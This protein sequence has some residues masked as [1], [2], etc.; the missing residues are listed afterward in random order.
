MRQQH[1]TK[2]TLTPLSDIHHAAYRCLD[3]EQTRWFYED[4]MGLKMGIALIED[5]DFGEDK[6]RKF[7]HIF[8]E[9]TNG[10]SVAFFD[11]P[12]SATPDDFKRKD[13]FN[14]HLAFKTDTYEE[15]IA[16]QDRINAAGRGCYGPIDHGFVKSIY[17]YDPNGIQIEIAWNNND[18]TVKERELAINHEQLSQWTAESRQIK[19]EK[20]G[21]IIDRRGNPN[22][23]NSKEYK[24]TAAKASTNK[25]KY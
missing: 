7:M 25:D 6:P 20:F 4:V 16:W 2:A 3:A 17:V 1:M 11:H 15:L 18:T 8:F 22:K 10:A 14:L 9:C 13:S 5:I 21:D 12:D 24:D 19:L 23:M